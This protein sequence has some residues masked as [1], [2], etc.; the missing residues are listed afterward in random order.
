MFHE[1]GLQSCCDTSY[2]R[3]S[4]Q[5]KELLKFMQLRSLFL[6]NNIKTFDFSTLCKT[7]PHT[8]LKE[9]CQ[10]CFIKKMANVDTNT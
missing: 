1:T 9:Y 3:G 10:L 7:I 2:S 5:N 8:K 4:V 6:C